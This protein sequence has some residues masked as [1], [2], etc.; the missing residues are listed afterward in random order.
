MKIKFLLLSILFYQVSFAQTADK[1]F[2]AYEQT[3]PGSQIKFK[4]VPIHGGK[5]LM[6]SPANET[7][8]APDE[9]PQK[10]FQ[11]SSFWIGACEVTHDEFDLFFKDGS[12]SQDAET[13]AVTR[14]SPQY[15]DLTWEMGR[16]GGY[17]VNS[18]QQKTALMYCRWLYKKTGVF[19]RLP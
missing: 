16:E 1:S 3:I 5:F 18:M 10:T 13:D 8:R 12:I 19:Y 9:G 6:G 15:I 11:L 14:P 4:M 7:G 2:A 17:P